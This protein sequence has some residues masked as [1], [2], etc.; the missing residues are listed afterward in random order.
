MVASDRRELEAVVKAGSSFKTV[1]L[2]FRW[3]ARGQ[4]CGQAALLVTQGPGRDN[5]GRDNAGRATRSVCERFPI[6]T[7][8]S[9]GIVGGLDPSLC[10]GDVVLAQSILELSSGV[11]Y[12]VRLP[13]YKSASESRDPKIGK[14]VT[15]DIVVQCARAKAELRKTGVQAVD[16]ESGAVAAEAARRGLRMFCVRAVSD[17]AQATFE[18]DFNRARR[19][20]GSFSGRD[21]LIQAGFSRRRW[22]HLLRLRRDAEIAMAALGDFFGRCQFSGKSI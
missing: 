22:K 10:I 4:I 15:A 21:V 18:I 20:D 6:E 16:M 9:A 13:V 5:A 7:V 14:L 1:D 17:T 12:P 11:E 8:V 19:N 2:G 3:S